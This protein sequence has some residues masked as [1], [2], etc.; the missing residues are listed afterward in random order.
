MSSPVG[1]ALDQ[2]H[3]EGVHVPAVWSHQEWD[4][5]VD[6]TTTDDLRNTGPLQP[7]C[8]WA[9]GVGPTARRSRRGEAIAAGSPR[10]SPSCSSQGDRSVNEV[11]DEMVKLKKAMEASLPAAAH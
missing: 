7:E 2:W 6:P 4:Q 1:Q 8:G 10:G 5:H 11:V 3:R 9:H